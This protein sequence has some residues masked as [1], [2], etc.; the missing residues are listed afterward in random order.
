MAQK[1]NL[2]FVDHVWETFGPLL[3]GIPIVVIPDPVVSEPERLVDHLA[4]HQVTRIVLVP[5]LLEIIL[6]SVVDLRRRLPHL[7]YWTS[8]GEVL[9]GSLVCKFQSL[10]PGR[11]LLNLYGSSEVAADVTCYDTANYDGEGSVPIGRPIDNTL[12]YLLDDNQRPVPPG[13]RGRSTWE[14]R[15]SPA[16]ISTTGSSRASDSSTIHWNSYLNMPA[17]ST[18]RETT[19]GI[20]RM[21]KSRFWE[22]STARSNY[23]VSGSNPE[24]SSGRLCGHPSVREAGVVLQGGDCGDKRLTAYLVMKPDRDCSSDSLSRYLRERLPAAMIPSHWE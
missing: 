8:S 3:Q 11:V 2:T 6:D 23:G 16:D 7:H 4:H 22:E 1:T 12:I 21:V 9:S 18:E 15:G 20:E 14:G 13:A 19:D 10:L 24:R 17:G 5:A